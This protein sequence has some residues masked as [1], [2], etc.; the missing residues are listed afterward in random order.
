V[1]GT[2]LKLRLGDF[3]FPRATLTVPD[4]DTLHAWEARLKDAA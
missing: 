1:E 3:T 2:S 4:A